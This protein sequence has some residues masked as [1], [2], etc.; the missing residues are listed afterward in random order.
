MQISDYGT[1]KKVGVS[2]SL[3]STV[4]QLMNLREKIYEI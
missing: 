1:V 3:D 2:A 4:I